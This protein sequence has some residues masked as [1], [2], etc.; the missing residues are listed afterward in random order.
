[1]NW[2]PPNLSFTNFGGLTDGNYSLNRNQTSAVGDSLLWVRGLHN[3]T[4][5]GDYRRQQFNQ[6]ADTNG[7]GTYTFNGSATS[8]LVNGVAQTGTGYD[9]ADFLLGL[10]TTSSIRYRQPR[11]V[12]SRLAATTSSSMTTGASPPD[13]A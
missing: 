8:L 5:G 13:S 12:L 11:Q 10:P 2:G 7:R 1:M 4:F 6:L 9:L 3:F